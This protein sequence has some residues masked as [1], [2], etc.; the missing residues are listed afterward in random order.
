M[1]TLTVKDVHLPAAQLIKA[2]T[3]YVLSLNRRPFLVGINQVKL[4]A[5]EHHI[6]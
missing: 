1:A 2:I 3:V 6:N 4:S 5:R